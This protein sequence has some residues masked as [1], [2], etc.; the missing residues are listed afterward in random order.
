MKEIQTK[1]NSLKPY[2]SGIR[3]EG[4][5]TVVNVTLEPSWEVPNNTNDYIS[6]EKDDSTPNSYLFY[7]Q[8]EKITIDDIL[9]YVQVIINLNIEREEKQKLL[10]EK[11]N[12]LKKLFLGDLSLEELK[13]ITF[14]V[15]GENKSL[16]KEEDFDIPLRTTNTNPNKQ[17]PPH[18][19]KKEEIVVDPIITNLP[20]NLSPEEKK[21]ISDREKMLKEL[22]EDVEIEE[23]LNVVNKN[24]LDVELPPKK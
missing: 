24:G 16:D 13:T 20:P 3:F 7:T 17:E 10:V 8:N 6:I 12:Q 2:V 11:I 9:E 21:R 19:I 1:I 18:E 14:K 4:E 22:E 5:F 23:P 15:N